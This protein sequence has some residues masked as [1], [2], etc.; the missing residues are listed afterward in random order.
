ML[1][2][3]VA[4]GAPLLP[5][6]GPPLNATEPGREVRFGRCRLN[7]DARRLYDAAGAEVPITAMEFDLLE[8]LARHPDR[9]LSRDRLLDLAH[10]KETAPFDRSIDTRIARLRAKIEDDPAA[11][12]TIRTV[13]GVGYVFVPAE[14]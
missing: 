10:R 3:G 1:P 13:R 14:G 7:L 4:A 11:P 9:V 5:A 2:E 8:V 6:H 12:R